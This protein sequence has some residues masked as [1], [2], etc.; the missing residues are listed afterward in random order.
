MFERA[1]DTCFAQAVAIGAGRGRDHIGVARNRALMNARQP[2]VGIDEAVIE[3][4]HWRE[5]QVDP[6]LGK[7]SA[8]FASGLA[9][10]CHRFGAILMLREDLGD[11][12]RPWKR[13]REAGDVAALLIPRDP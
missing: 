3:V 2:V 12:Q 11:A 4:D 10:R 13:R 5:V 1:V 8:L 7:R 9:H 6:R